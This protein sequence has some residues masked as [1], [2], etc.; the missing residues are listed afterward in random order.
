[1]A[2]D[3]AFFNGKTGRGEVP[4]HLQKTRPESPLIHLWDEGPLLILSFAVRC[5][6]ESSPPTH[7]QRLNRSN[8]ASTTM[9]CGQGG[10]A[11]PATPATYCL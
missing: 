9:S 6:S 3:R 4:V 10:D 8:S 11:S 5:T 7:C 1:M 2:G